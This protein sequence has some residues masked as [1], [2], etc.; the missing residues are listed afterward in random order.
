MIN[1]NS[2]ILKLNGDTVTTPFTVKNG[3]SLYIKVNK[4]DINT[5]AEIELT[6]III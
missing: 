1:T 4:T 2:K 5:S 6:G 3:D